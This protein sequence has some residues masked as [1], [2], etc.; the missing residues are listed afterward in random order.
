MMDPTAVP[1]EQ[2]GAREVTIYSSPS[3]ADVPEKAS[4]KAAE[5]LQPPRLA[6]TLRA[7]TPPAPQPTILAVTPPSHTWSEL[8]VLVPQPG[9]YAGQEIAF[10]TP[11]K[12]GVPTQNMSVRVQDPVAPG[13]IITVRYPCPDLSGFE[14]ASECS[15]PMP[16]VSET[17]EEDRQAMKI[18]WC[19][20]AAGAL[21]GVAALIFGG[22]QDPLFIAALVLWLAAWASYI[23]QPKSVRAR[24]PRQRTPAYTSI[25][26]MIVYVW[27]TSGLWL[28]MIHS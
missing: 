16:S 24:R 28:W 1:F 8:K 15:P 26:T 2:A 3:L 10:D 18:A 22:I 9:L 14:V 4:A 7:F 19:I 12:G 6:S 17:L 11:T 23:C 13:S 5:V 20:Y 27:G 21:A 25:V